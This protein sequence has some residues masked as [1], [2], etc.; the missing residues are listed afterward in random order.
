MLSIPTG[1]GRRE[2]RAPVLSIPT[3][4][5]GTESR[6]PYQYPLKIDKLQRVEENPLVKEGR[7]G[8]K[9][10]KEKEKEL[11]LQSRKS[12]KGENVIECRKAMEEKELN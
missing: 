5:G 3:V 8:K 1:I 11:K 4:S 12:K 9:N 2:S 6:A 7:K 10:E